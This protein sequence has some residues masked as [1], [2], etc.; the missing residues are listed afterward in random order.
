MPD[1]PKMNP[2]M[3]TD[4]PPLSDEAAVELDFLHE[5][6]FRFEGHYCGQ[7]FRYY[8]QQKEAQLASKVAAGEKF[9]NPPFRCENLIIT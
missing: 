4:L 3:P 8:D 9:S 1:T 6:V 5:L 2:L 7:I